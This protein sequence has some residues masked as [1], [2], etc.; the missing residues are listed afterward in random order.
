MSKSKTRRE[1]VGKSDIQSVTDSL[2]IHSPLNNEYQ[3]ISTQETTADNYELNDNQV[4]KPHRL[5]MKKDARQKNIGTRLLNRQVSTYARGDLFQ[6]ARDGHIDQ[7][8]LLQENNYANCKLF[9]NEQDEAKLTALHYA[10]RY[11]HFN[12][13]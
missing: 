10:A 1:I 12:V 11:Y 9:F 5:R 2:H 4:K 8:K 7:L 13:C 6:A 3:L